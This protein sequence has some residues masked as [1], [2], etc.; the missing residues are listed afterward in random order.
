MVHAVRGTKDVMGGKRVL[1]CNKKREREMPTCVAV[2]LTVF[3][4]FVNNANRRII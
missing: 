4:S 1:F 3:V 2:F